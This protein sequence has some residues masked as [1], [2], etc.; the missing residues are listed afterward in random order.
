[1]TTYHVLGPLAVRDGGT[2]HTPRG[3]KI[4]KVLALLLLRAGEVVSV[5]TLAEELWDERPPRT[6]VTT[7]R[8][9]VYHLRKA[10]DATEDGAGA[11]R[12][13]PTGYRL[14]HL[15]GPFDA[16]HFTRATD[17]GHALLRRDSP[18]E[19]ATV[20]RTALGMWRGS[21]LAGID[22][23]PVL[24][25]HVEHLEELRVRALEL[26]IEADMALG[27][28][29]QL[30]PELRGLV[31]AHPLNEWFHARLIDALHRSGRRSDALRAYGAVRGL[32]DRELG[33]EPSADLQRVQ[34]EVLTSGRT[35]VV[36]AS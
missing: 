26:R 1:M 33:L 2:D 19:A 17:R 34:Q 18:A 15:P 31:A 8:T 13:E 24:T 12:T 32:L 29:R 21:A 23:G 27:R 20:L 36:A 28:H 14:S 4:G 30:V 9:H 6:A 5:R 7:I 10:L 3:P 25:R 11:L 35:P 16:H 22:P